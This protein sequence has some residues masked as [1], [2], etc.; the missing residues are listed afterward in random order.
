VGGIRRWTRISIV[1]ALC[2]SAAVV[3]VYAAELARLSAARQARRDDNCAAADQDLATCWRLP[4]IVNAIDMEEELLGVQQG[5]LRQEKE[6]KKRSENPTDEGILIL[7]ALA[8]GNLATAQFNEARTYAD[9]ILKRQP[10]QAR[11][12]WLRGR[13]WV[14]VQQEEKG[15][16]DL[17]RAVQLEPQAA[18]IR[19]SLADLLHKL[20]HVQKALTHYEKVCREGSTDTRVAL[21]LAHCLQDQGRLNDAREVLD[22]L[23]A[24]QPD[25]IAGLVERSRLAIRMDQVDAAEKWLR[26]ALKLAPENMEA[27]RVLVL[28]LKAQQK[29]DAEFEKKWE[30]NQRQQADFRLKL[31]EAGR[32]PALLT[33]YGNWVWKSGDEREA[34][35]WFY[36]ALKEDPGYAPAHTGL[37]E[38]FEKDGQTQRASEHAHLAE[39]KTTVAVA[40]KQPAL[41]MFTT[42][43]AR[44][45]PSAEEDRAGEATREEVLALCMACH[46]YPPP[47][48]MPRA[49]WRKE[50]KQGYDFLRGSTLHA[51]FPPLESVV[52]YYEQR[53]PERLPFV[54][55]SPATGKPPVKFEKKGTGW[56]VQLPP[57]PGVANAALGHL[58]GTEKQE[59][60]LC[61][62]RLD[63]VLAVKPYETPPSGQAL[64]QV[65]APSRAT[66]VDLDRD[67]RQDVLV[68]GLGN[69]FPTDDKVG[70]VVWL[71]ALPEGG[72][73]TKTLLEG[74]GRVADVQAGDF[75]SD[76]KLDL[77]VAVFGWR[78]VG[79]VLL[80]ENR[81][82][83]WDSPE[84]ATTV[85]DARHGAI[86]AQSVDLNGDGRS[87][88]VAL[89]SQEHESVVAY[90]NRGGG[91]FG[92]E[93]LFK[94]PHPSYG[95]SGIEV[96]DVDGDGDQDV[97]LTNGDVL[98]RPY[99]LKPYHGVQW[100]ENKEAFPFEH[101]LIAPMYGASRAVAA[102]FDGDGDQDVAAVSF[103][104][105][106]EFP[107][108]ER[109]RL[110]S[111]ALFEQTAK[112]EFAMHVL[113]AGACDHFSCEAGDWDG[114][115]KIDLAVGNYSWKRSQAFGDAAMLWRNLGRAE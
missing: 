45:N 91:A 26:E 60:L 66:V 9:E 37:A 69:F 92:Q 102:D 78:T 100:L 97:L 6:W 29:T 49:A 99:L 10:E 83:D 77:V 103:L 63:R 56:M 113:E 57:Y 30:A 5:D 98:D 106:L 7:E 42:V 71:R 68:A 59:L 53:A 51:D 111:V 88:I 46:A 12:L 104:P 81:T 22:W 36:A 17:E 21:R 47:D 112:G 74:V 34:V 105:K 2:A 107:E 38:Y 70:K 115:G 96:V 33:E 89:I 50:V 25:S 14:Q 101:H 52:R 64:G 94:A 24:A 114:D 15:Q 39:K 109:L 19:L 27:S 79:E 54:K 110:P 82:Q 16:D 67:G 4:G 13:A 86:H 31:H 85:L 58:F 41:R 62:T 40:K 90:M 20:G 93:T 73:A 75:T 3:V 1:C 44:A 48:S 55:Q 11:A 65:I 80:L 108:R 32:V 76:G 61:D 84:F 87:D 18:V 23:L 72:F 8:K 28:C 95:S 35:G 43:V